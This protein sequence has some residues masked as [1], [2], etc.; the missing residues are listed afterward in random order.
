[1][2]NLALFFNFKPAFAADPIRFPSFRAFAHLLAIPV[3]PRGSSE[4][5][6][7]NPKQDSVWF[8]A[9]TPIDHNLNISLDS[10]IPPR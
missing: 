3:M 4:A 6:D 5:Q 9:N 10:R 7:G 8:V 2:C 1:M